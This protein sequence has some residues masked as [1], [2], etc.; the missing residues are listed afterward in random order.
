MHRMHGRRR[1]A[2]TGHALQNTPVW[3]DTSKALWAPDMIETTAMKKK[4]KYVVYFAARLNPA[5][6]TP[7]GKDAHPASGARCIGS[8]EP[9]SQI[10]PFTVDAKPV[11]CRDG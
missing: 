6:G 10:G 5:A 9:T 4:K 1:A 3:M 11:V 2:P 7:T 8:A